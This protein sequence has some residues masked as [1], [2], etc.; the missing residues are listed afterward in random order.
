MTATLSD[1]EQRTV[2]RLQAE[3]DA[4]PPDPPFIA[5]PDSVAAWESFTP[6]EQARLER[7]YSE[8]R[9]SAAEEALDQIGVEPIVWADFWKRDHAS[10]EWLVEPLIPIGRQ[11][12]VYSIAKVGKSLLSLEIAAAMA[13]GCPVL[14]RPAQEPVSVVYIDQEMNQDDVQERLEDFGYSEV[15]DLSH[16]Y[17]YQMQALPALDTAEGGEVVAQI[18]D[19]HKPVIVIIDTMASV[20][21]GGEN[22]ADTYRAFSR[23][24]G[25]KIRARGAAL[26]RLD[27]SGKDPV[28]GQRGSSAKVG[29]VDVVFLLTKDDEEH[30]RL[31]RT[32][33]RPQWV[34]QEIKIVRDQEHW[35][36]HVLAPDSYP[37]GTAGA[38][39]DLDRL[40]VPVDA[41]V[42][43]A[44]KAM[45]AAGEGKRVNVVAAA[46]KYRRERETRWETHSGN[47][48]GK[49]TETERL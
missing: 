2:R 12:A 49:Q 1:L 47:T 31:V 24:T 27:H 18:M 16:L 13:T 35:L 7:I 43:M 15:D 8:D 48:F 44:L 32:H 6:K 39:D 30:F 37:A 19:L 22:D 5:D 38:A 3:H 14:G 10:H 42:R 41:T 34:P 26:L 9:Y 36:R 33:S 25:I 40:A 29:D 17:Y 4:L 20:V 21:D 23:H 46:L 28:K 45:R 11:V